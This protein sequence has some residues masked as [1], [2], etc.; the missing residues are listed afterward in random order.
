MREASVI[1]VVKIFLK[2]VALC[3]SLF[4]IL[5]FFRLISNYLNFSGVCL[6]LFQ[7]ILVSLVCGFFLE[8]KR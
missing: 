8:W 2:P 6:N 1:D 3:F 4:L 7:T 5:S